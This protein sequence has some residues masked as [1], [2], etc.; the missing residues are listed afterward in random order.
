MSASSSGCGERRR[1][2]APSRRM[3][4]RT[5]SGAAGA[6]MPMRLP[7]VGAAALG[8]L[9]L[10]L[11]HDRRVAQRRDVAELAALGDVAQQAAHDLA[12]A[13]LGQVAGPD[14]ALGA[15]ELA[16]PLGDVLAQLG[17]QVVGAVEVAL[18]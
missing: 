17:H 3:T 10:Q 2:T 8:D 18:E 13:R 4:S 16:D 1:R 15:R 6:A 7:L 11:L 12:R 14:D 9:L 5:S